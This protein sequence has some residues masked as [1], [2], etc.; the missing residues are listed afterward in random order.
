MTKANLIKGKWI[1]RVTQVIDIKL[2]WKYN[3]SYLNQGDIWENN[4]GKD[5]SR[6]Y[7]HVEICNHLVKNTGKVNEKST[8]YFFSYSNI[9]FNLT[10]TTKV[11]TKVII[12]S[13]AILE[14]CLALLEWSM[15]LKSIPTLITFSNLLF[16]GQ[17]ELRTRV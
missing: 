7:F 15:L 2:D 9:C 16:K 8:S 1:V 14:W 6:A 17:K 12:L 10:D 4:R 11:I 3:W 13:L 5:M